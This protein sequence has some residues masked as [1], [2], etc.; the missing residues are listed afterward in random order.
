MNRYALAGQIVEAISN[1]TKTQQKVICN[2]YGAEWRLAGLISSGR[3]ALDGLT[4]KGRD[5]IDALA[6]AVRRI[7]RAVRSLAPRVPDRRSR[8]HSSEATHRRGH[9]TSRDAGM[10]QCGTR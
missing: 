3:I 9:T 7:K 5:R 6:L 1:R 8:S 10:P 2:N 4:T